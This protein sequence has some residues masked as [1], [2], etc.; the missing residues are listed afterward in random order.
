MVKHMLTMEDKLEQY[1]A[2]F[3]H[4]HMMQNVDQIIALQLHY[5]IGSLSIK[6]C[7]L[8]NCQMAYKISEG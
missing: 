3:I 4:N 7:S 8:Q 5:L 2:N 1:H 6:N